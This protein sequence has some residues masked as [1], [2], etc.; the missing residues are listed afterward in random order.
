M[1]NEVTC[2]TCGNLAS[3]DWCQ[4]AEC[5]NCGSQ[6]NERQRHEKNMAEKRRRWAENRKTSIVNSD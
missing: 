1:T 3:V 2:P 4:K 5:S 6:W